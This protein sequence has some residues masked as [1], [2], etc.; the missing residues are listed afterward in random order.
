M[1]IGSAVLLK[2]SNLSPAELISRVASKGGTTEQALLK[3][4]EADFDGAI[5]NAM[6]ACTKRADELG[7]Q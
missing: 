2:G 4:D 5:E 6:K 1:V 7:K 3:L